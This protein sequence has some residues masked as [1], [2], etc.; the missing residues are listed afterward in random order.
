M[1]RNPGPGTGPVMTTPA[2]VTRTPRT[3]TPQRTTAGRCWW[4]SL[5]LWSF[6]IVGCRFS[7]IRGIVAEPIIEGQRFAR[8][9]QRS[10]VGGRQAGH[11][12]ACERLDRLAVGGLDPLGPLGPRRHRDA[13]HRQAAGARRLD[14]HSRGADGAAA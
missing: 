2:A 6:W 5:R 1:I 7:A 14:R 12:D 11:G 3:T 8:G 4:R 13:G 10:R 9:R